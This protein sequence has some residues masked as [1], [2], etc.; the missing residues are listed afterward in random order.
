MG[1]TENE[2]GH[3]TYYKWKKLHEHYKKVYNFET[4]KFLFDL[5]QKDKVEKEENIIN[6]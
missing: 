1:F 5:E 6:F 2:V 4:N 3:M